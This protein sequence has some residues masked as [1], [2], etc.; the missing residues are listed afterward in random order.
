MNNKGLDIL[1]TSW[2]GYRE[3]RDKIQFLRPTFTI[4]INSLQTRN[5][6]NIFTSCSKEAVSCIKHYLMLSSIHSFVKRSVKTRD[7][8]LSLE[9]CPWNVQPHCAW[10]LLWIAREPLKWEGGEKAIEY[11]NQSI[12]N[13]LWRCAPNI[14]GRILMAKLVPNAR[15]SFTFRRFFVLAIFGSQPWDH[16]LKT[17]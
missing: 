16:F 14:R 8:D 11:S 13:T 17:T 10:S 15:R 5:S 7:T 9:R 12:V 3:G 6:W 2:G 1:R 4:L